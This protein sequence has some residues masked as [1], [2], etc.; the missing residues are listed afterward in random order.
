MGQLGHGDQEKRL[1]P[2]QIMAL[3]DTVISSASAGGRHTLFLA[4]DGDI[5]SCGYNVGGTLGHGLNDTSTFVPIPRSISRSNVTGRIVTISAGNVHSFLLSDAKI[6]YSFGF[7]DVCDIYIYVS[8][9][10]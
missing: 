3:N 4:Q 9:D 10:R 6:L 1:V 5:Y 8:M 2:V 7:N